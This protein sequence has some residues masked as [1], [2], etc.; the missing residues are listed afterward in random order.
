MQQRFL[1]TR[2]IITMLGGMAL[3]LAPAHGQTIPGPDAKEVQACLD[4]ACQHL[5]DSQEAYDVTRDPLAQGRRRRGVGKTVAPK[6]GSEWPYEGVYR[7][8]DDKGRAPIP[9]GYRVGGTAI[10]CMGLLASPGFAT[11]EDRQEAVRKGV[12]FIV[13]FMED[14]TDMDSS[15][16]EGYDVRGWG[17][18]YALEMALRVLDQEDLLDGTLK[19][20]L[21]RTVTWLIRM[22]QESEIK[23]RGGWNYARRGRRGVAASASTFMTAPTILALMRAKAQGHEVDEAVVKRALKTLEDAR[24]DDLGTFQYG[25]GPGKGKARGSWEHPAGS[26]GRSAVSE[27]ALHLAGRGSTDR[28]RHAVMQFFTYWREL[29]ARYQQTGTHVPQ[30]FMIAPYYFYFAH[31]YAGYAIEQ[32]PEA[33]RPYLRGLLREA[34]WKTKEG[35]GVWNDRVFPR[36]SSYGSAMAILGLTAAEQPPLPGWKL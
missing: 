29:H 13:D 27:L 7:I 3:F 11:N 28:L 2:L 18:A 9:P 14:R 32:L 1:G 6:Q 21:E 31:T 16:T 17:H 34:Y 12:L 10:G 20:R 22:I 33:E 35:K 19:R 15:F 4:A 23:G 5:L 24:L 30:H 36:S 26:S 8:R 25:S